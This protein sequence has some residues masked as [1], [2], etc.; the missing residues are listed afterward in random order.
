MRGSGG[1]QRGRPGRICRTPNTHTRGNVVLER[2]GGGTL[3]E[4]LNR[5]DDW[6]RNNGMLTGEALNI[7]PFQS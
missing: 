3:L 4:Q 2:Y 6:L 1:M 5:G 7:G